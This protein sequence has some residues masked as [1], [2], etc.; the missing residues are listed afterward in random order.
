MISLIVISKYF[1]IFLVFPYSKHVLFGNMLFNLDIC[2]FPE[3]SLLLIANL[4]PLRPEKYF[5]NSLKFVKA[6]ISNLWRLVLWTLRMVHPR[7]CSIHTW[8]ICVFCCYWV[9][10]P[11]MSSLVCLCGCWRLFHP[12]WSSA[13]LL[14]IIKSGLLKSPNVI[15]FFL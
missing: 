1:L 2:K 6:S 15:Y 9:Y 14:S 3:I 10:V 12:C 11:Q 8:E 13:Y 4:I 7:E 5:F